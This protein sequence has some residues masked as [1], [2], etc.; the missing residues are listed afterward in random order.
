VSQGHLCLLGTTSSTTSPQLQSFPSSYNS[1]SIIKCITLHAAA[2]LLSEAIYATNLNGNLAALMRLPREGESFNSRSRNRHCL[3]GIQQGLHPPVNDT[4][5]TLSASR[6]TACSVPS[7]LLTTA[8]AWVLPRQ[9]DLRKAHRAVR[10]SSTIR[11]H[12]AQ[13]LRCPISKPGLAVMISV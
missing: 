3:F 13:N 2:A 10:C 6:A 12:I 11:R 7:D 4:A 1:A 9:G 8:L 5:V